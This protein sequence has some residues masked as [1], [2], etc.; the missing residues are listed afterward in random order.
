MIPRRVLGSQ[1][2]EEILDRRCLS[3]RQSFSPLL[4]GYLDLPPDRA[5]L[6]LPPIRQLVRPEPDN[7]AVAMAGQLLIPELA[8]LPACFLPIHDE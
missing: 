4:G 1:P 3:E 6:A 2:V 5:R 7:V 8:I